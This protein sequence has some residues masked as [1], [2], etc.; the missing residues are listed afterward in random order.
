MVQDITERKQA[1][2]QLRL[3]QFS[4]DHASDAIFWIDPQGHIV[5]GNE[6]ACRSLGRSREE[7]LSLSISDID[8]LVPKEA[9]GRLWKEVKGCGSLT[10]E[11]QYQSKQGGV[12]PVEVTAN[13]LE[14][15]GKE[16]S[17]AFARDITERKRTEEA[18]RR[19][20]QRYKDFILHSH[21]GVW[22]VE[23]EPPIPIGLPEE[24]TFARLLQYGYIAE[25]NL[26]FA[27]NLGFASTEEIMG[28]RLR[29]LIHSSD[30]E[31]L[32]SLRSSVKGG[33][34]SRTVE[35]RGLDKSGNPK[36]FLRTEIPI[37]EN[38]MF[39]RAWGITR[40]IT[41]LK[42]AEEDRQRSLE[43][44]R[45]LAARLQHVREEERKHVAREIHD[46][47]GQA[48]TAI[49]LD[50]KSLALELPAKQ[51]QPINR[52]SSILT[53]IEDTIH[54]V[55]RISTELRPEM[56]DDLGLVTTLEWAAEEFAKR[57]GV[58]CCL[59]LPDESTLVDPDAATAIFR[60]FQE[61]LTNVARYAGA[62]EVTARLIKDDQELTLEVHDDGHGIADEKIDS[63]ESLGIL[64]MR[65]RALLLGGQ[66]TISG[67]PG[68]GTTVRVRIPRVH[69]EG[70]SECHDS[71]PGRR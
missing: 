68:R 43:Q 48:L 24:E 29:D 70:G 44:L 3:T 41:E 52:T 71:S 28:V 60:I 27:R 47:L 35:F 5:Y 54:I 26:A 33:F 15:A 50:L 62:N 51:E 65:E 23:M 1:E 39:V 10:L 14:F 53:L 32:E 67:A 9:W 4:V 8:P 49:K 55:Q 40:E 21:E 66:F 7:L 18:L 46:Q 57:T 11:T 19:S 30:E 6:A 22:R 31:R 34:G 63:A 59:D 38:G 61:T 42:R 12:F 37:V 20:D 17:F 56:L 58:K 16:Y 45:A 25:C 69:V 36:H 2:E 64:G 13:Y